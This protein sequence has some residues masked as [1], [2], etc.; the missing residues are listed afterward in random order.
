MRRFIF[1]LLFMVFESK[2][3]SQQVIPLYTGSIP[4]AKPA[5]DEEKLLPDH[6]GTPISVAV[7]KPTLS[8]FLPK[9]PDGRALLICPGGG[10]S[11][12][13]IKHEGE[14]V[15]KKL[16]ESGITVFVLKYR[17]P[18][19]KWMVDPEIGPLQDVQQAIIMIRKNAA[20]WKIDP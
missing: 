6:N 18:N 4:N 16:S 3:F 9:K 11:I 10:Y 13:A 5:A 12:V 14:E 2:G 20:K 17:I 8:V 15:A 1:I 19:V 7:Q